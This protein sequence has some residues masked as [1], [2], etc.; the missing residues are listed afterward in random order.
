MS[1]HAV[2]LL[3]PKQAVLHRNA[4]ELGSESLNWLPT[5]RIWEALHN[6]LDFWLL[7]K[8]PHWV[9]DPS[10]Q[11]PEGGSASPARRLPGPPPRGPYCTPG[12]AFEEPQTLLKSTC[13]N[14]RKRY[15]TSLSTSSVSV[16]KRL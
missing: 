1:G 14:S 16:Q 15:L 8:W 12:S 6:N 9:R 3:D 4:V 7:R 13:P 10:G 5:F 2:G 11:Q